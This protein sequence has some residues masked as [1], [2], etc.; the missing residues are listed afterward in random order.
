MAL[1]PGSPALAT[2]YT[3]ATTAEDQRGAAGAPRT[4]GQRADIGAYESADFSYIVSYGL[5][6]IPSAVL[7]QNFGPIT[8]TVSSLN[9]L[10]A[11]AL[12]TL[13]TS[14]GNVTLTLPA[15]TPGQPTAKGTLTQLFDSTGS[16]TF[17]LTAANA[18]GDYTVGIVSDFATASGLPL[19]GDTFKLRNLGIDLLITPDLIIQNYGASMPPL[20][21]TVNP[22]AGLLGTDTLSLILNGVLTV[23]GSPTSLGTYDIETA[24]LFLNAY[25]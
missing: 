22:V 12:P 7:G 23:P 24:T 17:L 21:Y 18:K 4:A 16:T 3:P 11:A 2:G 15:G 6:G 1:L 8:V 14:F 13:S 20:T 9:P 25:G 10:L 19:Q 5:P